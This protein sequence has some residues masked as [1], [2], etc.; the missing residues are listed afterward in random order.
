M[1]DPPVIFNVCDMP[2]G[3]A[4]NPSPK[5][6]GEEA[7]S[8]VRLA[9]GALED[10]YK[11]LAPHAVDTIVLGTD[12]SG[13]ECPSMALTALNVR[14]SLAFISDSNRHCRKVLQRCFVV[15]H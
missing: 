3:F 11:Q 4:P 13:I 14:H 8:S 10:D 2:S 7:A 1:K 12:C 5:K 9:A 6:A 15:Q